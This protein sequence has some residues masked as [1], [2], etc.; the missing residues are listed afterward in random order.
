MFN[1]AGLPR[2]AS[3][4][5]VHGQPPLLKHTRKY[6]VVEFSGKDLDYSVKKTARL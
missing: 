4:V 6:L 1:Q 2:S 3:A 5:L